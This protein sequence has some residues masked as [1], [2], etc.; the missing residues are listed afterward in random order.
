MSEKKLDQKALRHRDNEILKGVFRYLEHPGGTL[1]F[2]YKKYKE[3][4]FER[5]EL[6][7]G[8][9]YQLPRM[10]VRHLNTGVGYTE[11]KHL[12]AF[13]GGVI[14]GKNQGAPSG[15][16]AAPEDMWAISKK[17]RCEFVPLDFIDDASDFVTSP[18]VQVTTQK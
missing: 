4:P 14:A 10:V 2:H 15:G 6:K 7:D 9:T 1:R 13:G 12:N 11:Y 3:D 8:V 5:Y 17:R 16:I 18:I